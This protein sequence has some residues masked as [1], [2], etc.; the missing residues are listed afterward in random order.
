MK[1]QPRHFLPPPM[2]PFEPHGS[3]SGRCNWYKITQESIRSVKR[4]LR[5]YDIQTPPDMSEAILRRRAQTVV[6]YTDRVIDRYKTIPGL[7]EEQK[8][9][10][11]NL[12][13]SLNFVPSRKTYEALINLIPEDTIEKAAKDLETLLWAWTDRYFSCIA[14]ISAASTAAV[15]TINQIGR[16]YNEIR[17]DFGKAMEEA[18]NAKNARLQQIKQRKPSINPLQVTSAASIDDLL[19]KPAG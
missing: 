15:E 18:E 13:I 2:P 11:G 1:K 3:S 8:A 10:T 17:E 9:E 14:P 12:W 19:G 6:E 16:R 5:R 4:Y 7:E